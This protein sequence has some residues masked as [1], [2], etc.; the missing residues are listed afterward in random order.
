[1]IEEYEEEQKEDIPKIFKPKL[2]YTNENFQIFLNHFFNL[3]TPSQKDI[4]NY[5]KLERMNININ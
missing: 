2:K 4:F 1:M 5:F 3:I